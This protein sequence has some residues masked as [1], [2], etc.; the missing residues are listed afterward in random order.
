L[1]EIV[2]VKDKLNEYE[3]LDVA[4]LQHGFAPFMRD[5]DVLVEGS[6][7]NAHGRYLYRFTHCPE[8]HVTTRLKDE[9]WRGSWSDLYTDYEQW[10]ETG[11]PPGFVWGVCWSSAYP[12]LTY[13]DDSSLAA[14]WSKRFQKPMHEVTIETQVFH[15][16][17]VFQDV[18][19]SKLSDEVKLIDKVNIPLEL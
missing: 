2:T 13:V 15:L 3:L 5:Y 19:I 4:I 14:E 7:Q 6:W 10:M 12:G 17:I 9:N 8:A 16:Q 11:G 1:A 18:V